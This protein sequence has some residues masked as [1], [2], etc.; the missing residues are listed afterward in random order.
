M[1]SVMLDTS[2]YSAFKRGHSEIVRAIQ[3]ADLVGMS[4]VAI[5]ELLAGFLRGAQR[6][7]NEEELAAFLRSP[8]VR[9]TPLDEETSR[10][11]AAILGSLWKAGTPIPTNDIWIAAGAMQ[12]GWPVLCTDAHYAKIPQVISLCLAP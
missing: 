11:Y 5:G 7:K 10:R 12:W 1:N 6:K 8:R 3:E 2:A 9:I 4:P